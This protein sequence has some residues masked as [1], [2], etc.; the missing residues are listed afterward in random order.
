MCLYLSVGST[1]VMNAFCSCGFLHHAVH[2]WSPQQHSLAAIGPLCIDV[3]IVCF[4]CEAHIDEYLCLVSAI[5][6]PFPSIPTFRAFFSNFSAT[7]LVKR[8]IPVFRARLCLFRLTR[9]WCLYLTLRTIQIVWAMRR[10]HFCTN[11]TDPT[12]PTFK[13]VETS[14]TVVFV[15]PDV[16]WKW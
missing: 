1:T 15:V 4:K 8:T 16:P 5:L 11:S 2:R 3:G 12:F 14:R 7:I 10:G 13:V 9:R 6:P